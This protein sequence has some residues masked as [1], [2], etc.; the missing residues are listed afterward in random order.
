MKLLSLLL[1]ASIFCLTACDPKF[2]SNDSKWIYFANEKAD[3]LYYTLDKMDKADNGAIKIWVKAVYSKKLSIDDKEA[4]FAKNMYMI[5]CEA[6][7]YKINVGF[8]FSDKN[9]V[10]SKTA[11]SQP[12]VIPDLM[13]TLDRSSRE[14]TFKP[15]STAREEYFPIMPNSPVAALKVIACKK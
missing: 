7:T 9:E 5:N 10:V 8:Y 12:D 13:K 11:S 3:K 15:I 2:D 1:L 6:N 4:A 14:F